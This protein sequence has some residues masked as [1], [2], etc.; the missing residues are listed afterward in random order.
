MSNYD[1]TFADVI[2]TQ[3]LL[4]WISQY[5]IQFLIEIFKGSWKLKKFLQHLKYE[6]RYGILNLDKFVAEKQGTPL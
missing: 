2:H 5:F 4:F 6:L 1:V 3:I